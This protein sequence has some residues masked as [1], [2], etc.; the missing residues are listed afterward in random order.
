MAV[1]V[2]S[3]VAVVYFRNYLGIVL[4]TGCVLNDIFADLSWSASDYFLDW[5][6]CI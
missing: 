4:G 3:V 2:G 6:W 1:L 5:S